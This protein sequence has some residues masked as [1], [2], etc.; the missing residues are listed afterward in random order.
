MIVKAI[1]IT[2]EEVR[3]PRAAA[4]SARGLRNRWWESS[5]LSCLIL[6]T[7]RAARDQLRVALAGD[8]RFACTAP[9]SR[10]ELAADGDGDHELLFIDLPSLFGNWL[11][12]AL[13]IIESRAG[14][15][16]TLVVACGHEDDGDEEIAVR[17]RGA[18][19][20]LPGMSLG[21][22]V[23]HVTAALTR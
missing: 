18:G 5:R 12:D 19:L 21:D 1:G 14:R 8:R 23:N 7:D 3:P 22:A 20:Y 15:R 11:C 10:D 6:T 17:Q 13:D 4:R 2:S 9:A 16:A